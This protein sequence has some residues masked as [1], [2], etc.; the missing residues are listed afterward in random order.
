[1]TTIEPGEARIRELNQ[2]NVD[3]FMQ[4]NVQWY[5]E[6]LTDDFVCIESDGSRL[7]KAEFLESNKR[8]L[9]FSTTNSS[10]WMSAFLAALRSSMPL[11]YSPGEMVPK[12]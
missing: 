6:H 8:C 7:N 10:R 5:R 9:T 4:A 12:A 2:Q 1:M 3:A 11:G